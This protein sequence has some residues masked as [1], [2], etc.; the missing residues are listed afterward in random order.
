MVRVLTA[1]QDVFSALKHIKWLN[2]I[3]AQT[4]HCQITS[5]PAKLFN[6]VNL[7]FKQEFL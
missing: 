6:T 1:Y 4:N 2:L 7:F 3:T 5:V